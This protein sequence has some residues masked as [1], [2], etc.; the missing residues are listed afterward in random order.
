VILPQRNEA[1]LEELPEEVRQAIQFVFVQSVDE[2]LAAALEP[3]LAIP[4]DDEACYAEKKEK[5]KR[6][7]G[8]KVAKVLPSGENDACM[9]NDA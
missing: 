3:E 8:K 7:S 5:P 9:E 2:V 1:D 6:S 4:A